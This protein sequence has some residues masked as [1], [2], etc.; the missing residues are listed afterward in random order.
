M[1]TILFLTFLSVGYLVLFKW[2]FRSLTQERWQ[3]IAS[4]P[5]AMLENGVWKGL[6]FTYYGFFS[7]LAYT[8]AAA[9]FILLTFSL[10]VHFFGVFLFVE[11]MLAICIPA[12]SIVAWIVEKKRHTLTVGGASFVGIVFAPWILWGMNETGIPWLTSPVIPML[13]ATAIAYAFGEG[14]GRLACISF[15]CCYGKSLTESNEFVQRLFGRFNFVFSGKT[16]KIA[17]AGNMDGKPVVPVQ[18]LTAVLYVMTA[19]FCTMLFL[20]GFFRTSL[21]I[22]IAVTQLWRFFSETL[23]A[24]YRGEGNI[25]AYQKMA[26]ASICYVGALVFFFQSTTQLVDLTTGLHRIWGAE[27][28]LFLQLIFVTTFLHTGKSTVIGSTVRFH[29]E[30]SKI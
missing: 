4:V 12:S 30:T 16:K 8:I 14:T 20:Y 13:C 5:V 22:V 25:S 1:E 27:P 6:A 17:Y 26:L 2:A 11:L 23:R 15:G 18:A 29:V 24:D 7:A 9:M 19:I 28:L 21:V 10:N 3:F